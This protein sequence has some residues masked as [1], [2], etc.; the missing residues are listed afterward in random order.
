MFL[1]FAV[2]L[3]NATAIDLHVSGAQRIDGGHRLVESFGKLENGIPRRD[4]R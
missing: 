2:S 3:N 1:I 4:L